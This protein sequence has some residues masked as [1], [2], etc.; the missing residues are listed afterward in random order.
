METLQGINA[1]F[2]DDYA[3][4]ARPKPCTLL[5]TRSLFTARRQKLLHSGGIT[6]EAR[7]SQV[8]RVDI[9]KHSKSH[10]YRSVCRPC[11][12]IPKHRKGSRCSD[13]EGI[14]AVQF[15]SRE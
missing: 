2:V 5:F 15:Y 6:Q 8:K 1:Q 7:T 13:K 11:R 10:G 4:A 12:A 9:G 3:A 14:I